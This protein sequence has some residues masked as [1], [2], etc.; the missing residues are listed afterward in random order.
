MINWTRDDAYSGEKTARL[1]GYAA[2]ICPPNFTNDGAWGIQI[3]DEEDDDA[4]AYGE[5]HTMVEN[6]PTEA[7]AKRIAETILEELAM[8]GTRAN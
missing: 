5:T 1:S 4:M 3:F 7:S 8:T 2:V 6:L